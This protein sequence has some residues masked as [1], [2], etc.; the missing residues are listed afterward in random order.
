MNANALRVLEYE[1]LKENM[2]A[3]TAS[4]LGAQF[5]R[6]MRPAEEF[7]QVKELLAVTTEATTVY[8]LRDRYPF[9][10]LTDVRSEVKRAE[11]GS[12][13]S[14]SELL[15]VADV[16]YSGRQV[17]AFQERL[18]ED[19]PDLRLPRLDSRIEQITKLVEIEQGIRHA[20][21]DQGTV[22][23]SA[24][25]KLRALRSQLR[26]LEG[27]VR[28]KIDSV[29]RSKAKMLSDAIVTMRNDRYCVPVKQEYR[30][31]F[32]GIVHDQSASGATLFIEPQAVV[33]ANN[34]I[35]EA[36]LKERAEIERILAQLSALVGS[37]GDSLRINLD[38]LAEL[39][40]IMAKALYG[41]QIGAVEPRLNENRH[42]ILKEARHPFIPKEEVVP[43]TVSLGGDF[44]SL[45][46]TG[47][48]T[49]GK[50]VTLKTIG[51]LQLMVQSGLYVPAADETELSV[52]D[53]I[54]ADI[55]DEQSIEQNLSTFSS[56]MTNIVSMME[57]IDFMSLV[58]FDELGAG[59]DPTEGAALAIAI[60]D[61]V[62]RR[63]ARVA[64]TTHYSELKAYGYNRE[65]VVNASM[66]FDVESLSPTYRLLIGVP[67]RSNAFE[68]S[69]RLGLEDRIIDA[70]RGQIGSDA[71]SVETMIERLEE[72]KQRAE[73]LE[74]QLLEEKKR[75]VEEREQF[76]QEQAEIQEE[77]NEI[78]AKAE[79]KAAR[80]VER[81]QKEAEGVIKRLK[82]LRDAGA[83]KEHE[84]I[85]ARKRLEDAKPSL[86]EKRIAKVKA[87]YDQTPRFDKGE[88]VKVT[89]FNQ[90]GYIINQQANGEYTV[91]VGI[92]KV[93]VKPEDLAK[94]GSTPKRPQTKG[95]SGGTSVTKQSAPSAELDLRGVR[96]EE[97]LS[98]LER[99]MDQ[100]LL[101]N[102]DHIR[103][104]HGLGTGAM[105]QGVQEFL[106]GHRHVKG[107]RLGGQGEG[108][109]GVT[110]IEL[111]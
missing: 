101:S 39:D 48:N 102:Y 10:G 97:G 54:Y 6:A 103:V 5:V 59:T 22:Q 41:H 35:Q 34:E 94:I 2:L 21:D 7:E 87:K 28:S 11:I 1:K 109:H 38:V 86:Q 95:R 45:V 4:S 58:L 23:D 13:L 52:F 68:I 8:R 19:H 16:V 27:Q 106:K 25:D 17:K 81:A 80:A 63:G 107:H 71:Q 33:S 30:Q 64:A 100:A 46:I 92:M 69:K 67:G 40:F 74:A 73:T 70:A 42:I 18:H 65:G 15:S 85:E 83:V 76:E 36:R 3:F 98:K 91:Q 56:H 12:V 49:G 51:L 62:K 32:G 111:K 14:T 82:E 108:G 66:E 26:S 53:A 79:E 105:R 47:P 60:L 99:F 31:A 20:I 96:V 50:T 9:G 88:E 55:G 104:I 75:L 90:K 43:I 29:L 72:A 78:L 89:T 57:K 37:V 24:S 84:L 93:N 110:I 44:T 61:E 77:K